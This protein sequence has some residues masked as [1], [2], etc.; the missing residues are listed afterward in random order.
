MKACVKTC[1]ECASA[2]RDDGKGMVSLCPECAH[3]LYGLPA[4]GH[5]FHAGRCQTCWWDGSKSDFVQKLDK[6]RA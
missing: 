3:V 5:V 1:D 2:Y 4:C 6:Q